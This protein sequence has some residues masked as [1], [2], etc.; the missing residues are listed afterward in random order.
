[1]AHFEKW[2][3]MSDRFAPEALR[4]LTVDELLAVRGT[5]EAALAEKRAE[6]ERELTQISG[7]STAAAPLD[8]ETIH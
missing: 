2:E 1:M 4:M 3:P 5:V 6:I 8:G 7:A